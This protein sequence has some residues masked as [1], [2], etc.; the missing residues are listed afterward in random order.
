MFNICRRRGILVTHVRRSH[1]SEMKAAMSPK[2]HHSYLYGCLS[3]PTDATTQTNAA[4]R[5]RA[6]IFNVFHAQS[7]VGY[8]NLAPSAL[9]NCTR[10][11][12]SFNRNTNF[13]PDQVSSTAQTF[14]STSLALRPISRTMFSSKSVGTPAAFFG[15]EIQSMPSAF[16]ASRSLGISAAKLL[17]LAVKKCRKSMSLPSF[18]SLSN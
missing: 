11:H 8:R 7:H 5:A 10:T 13:N 12:L 9:V 2:G 1:A 18:C 4:L 16:I 17:R 15:Q 6:Q 14:T 3:L